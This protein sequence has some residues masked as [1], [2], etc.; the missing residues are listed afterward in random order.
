MVIMSRSLSIYLSFCLVTSIRP[1]IGP[2]WEPYIVE[3]VI[4]VD[5]LAEGKYLLHQWNKTIIE[6]LS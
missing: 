2:K 6:R 1:L 4:E 5:V 3:E